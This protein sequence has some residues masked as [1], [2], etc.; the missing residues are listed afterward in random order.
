MGID[1]FIG[2]NHTIQFSLTGSG[3]GK[4]AFDLAQLGLI[5]TRLGW[6][7]WL[8]CHLGFLILDDCL[9]LCNPGCVFGIYRGHSL[10]QIVKLGLLFC[11]CCQG[12]FG[13][14]PLVFQTRD[15]LVGF[16]DVGL[17]LFRRCGC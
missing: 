17:F 9:E 7:Q 2:L 5:R 6:R 11:W 14:I 3:L 13:H 15:D 16:G 12:C 10:L 8:L 4:L 1:R